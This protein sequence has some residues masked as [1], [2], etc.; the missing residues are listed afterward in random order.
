MYNAALW[1]NKCLVAQ[2]LMAERTDQIDANLSIRWRLAFEAQKEL[3]MKRIERYFYVHAPVEWGSEMQQLL[4][5]L[6]PSALFFWPVI[7]KPIALPIRVRFSYF[8]YQFPLGKEANDMIKFYGLGGIN[9]FDL[10]PILILSSIFAARSIRS[11]PALP[12]TPRHYIPH[13]PWS[14]SPHLGS[15]WFW[16][17]SIPTNGFW[18]VSIPKA[19]WRIVSKKQL[20]RL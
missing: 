4:A 7:Y 6:V 5:R 14:Q 19:S 12:G 17:W 20:G 11:T 8:G 9:S 1:L 13:M 3:S 10:W 2:S 16:T 15:F 18:C